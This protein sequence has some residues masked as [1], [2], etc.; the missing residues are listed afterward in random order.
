MDKKFYLLARARRHSLPEIIIINTFLI[1]K[2]NFKKFPLTTSSVRWKQR[3]K[4]LKLFISNVKFRKPAIWV[5]ESHHGPKFKINN[6]KIIFSRFICETFFC[7]C[8]EFVSFSVCSFACAKLYF[9]EYQ[10]N[11][12]WYFYRLYQRRFETTKRSISTTDANKFI[13]NN[14]KRNRF[15]YKTTKQ[16]S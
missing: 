9:V 3:I 8:F 6:L 12:E 16:K 2:K 13:A 4:N 7:C 10:K 11:L 15:D 14:T 1:I 5:C